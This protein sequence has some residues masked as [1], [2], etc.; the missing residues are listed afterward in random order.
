MALNKNTSVTIL[1]VD[2][3]RWTV[4]LNQPDFH[5][6][7]TPYSAM[8]THMNT[9]V[10]SHQWLHE[11]G[12]RLPTPMVKEG[13]INRSTYYRLYPGDCIPCIHGLPKIHKEGIL[14][15][16]IVSNISKHLTTTPLPLVGKTPHNFQNSNDLT[17]KLRVLSLAP[18]ETMGSFDIT[19][20]FTCIP[21]SKAVEIVRTGLM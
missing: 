8:K 1:P 18:E 15:R 21:T 7:I 6:K 2:K 10:W 12:Q 3:G 11:K 19:S 16:T 14:L 13:V 4:V 20:H 17:S 5:S 9:E